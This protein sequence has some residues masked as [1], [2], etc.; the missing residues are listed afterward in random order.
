[1]WPL[2]TLQPTIAPILQQLQNSKRAEL[3]KAH[4]T[5]L[6]WFIF[7]LILAWSFIEDCEWHNSVYISHTSNGSTLQMIINMLYSPGLG[8]GSVFAAVL[9]EIF[10][11]SSVT[12]AAMLYVVFGTRPVILLR[13]PLVTIGFCAVAGDNLSEIFEG[14][15]PMQLVHVSMTVILVSVAAVACTVREHSGGLQYSI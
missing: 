14:S 4:T 10:P 13:R 7:G 15:A 3:L 8:I 6:T 1:M 9:A 5:K 2:T 12:V 11:Q